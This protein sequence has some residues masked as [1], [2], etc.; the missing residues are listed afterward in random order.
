MRQLYFDYNATTPLAPIVQQAMLP[1][2]AEQYGNPSSSHALGRAAL[3]AI[4]D[5]REYLSLLIGCDPEELVFTSGGTE[6]NNLA[7]KGIAF[8]RGISEGGHFVISAIEH[9]S[10]VEPVKFLE[11]F[12]FEVTVV[13][14][15][16]QGVIQPAAVRQ[17]IRSDTLLVSIMLA[18]NEIG[19]VQPLKQ[20]ADICHAAGVT[21]HTDAAQAVGKIRVMVDELEI[22]LLTMAGH[23]MYAPKGVGALYVRQ[24]ILLEP[25]LHGAGHEAGMRAGTENV[26]AIAGLGAASVQAHKSLDAAHERME[27]LRDRLLESLRAG[28]GSELGIHGERAARLPNTLSVSFPGVIGQ[29]MLARIPE[30]C[31]STG[32]TCHSE[33]DAISPTLAAMNVS[34]EVARGTIRLSLGWYT[35]EDDVERA[36]SILLGA[37]E[38]LRK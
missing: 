29:E 7:V 35:S 12:G 25:L 5:A 16:S 33:T 23:K 38:G 18:N 36:A 31:A 15:T 4:E 21:L 22:D 24:G 19:T 37:W 10:V 2:L 26:A 17:A 3:E 11:R 6:S 28:V 9:P 27:K 20:I 8:R 13:P 30:L 14:V 32:S 34:P 1:L